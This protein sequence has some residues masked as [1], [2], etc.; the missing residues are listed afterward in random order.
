LSLGII[1]A[2]LVVAVVLSVRKNR[3]LGLLT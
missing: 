2:M 3:R 1:S